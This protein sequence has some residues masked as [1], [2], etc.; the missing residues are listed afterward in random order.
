MSLMERAFE[1]L[2]QDSVPLAATATTGNAE[3]DEDGTGLQVVVTNAGPD[4]AFICFGSSSVEATTAKVPIL[5][6]SSQPFTL[7][8]GDTHAAA[9]CGAD[10]TAQL[11]FTLGQGA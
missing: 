3:L 2:K 6:N 8:Q 11:Y 7:S 10:K 5:A 4:M 1:P 9:I